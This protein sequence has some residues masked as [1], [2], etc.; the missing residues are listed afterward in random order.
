MSLNYFNKIMNPNHNCYPFTNRS[1]P[2]YAGQQQQQSE[3]LYNNMR[4]SS[5]YVAP[6]NYARPSVGGPP[7]IGAPSHAA[8]T[9]SSFNKIPFSGPVHDDI[10]ASEYG[11]YCFGSGFTVLKL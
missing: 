10:S 6:T 9:S 11:R 5:P 4:Q 3:P 7:L 8:A 1:L 2:N